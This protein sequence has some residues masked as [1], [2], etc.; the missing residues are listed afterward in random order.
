MIKLL[1]KIIHYEPSVDHKDNVKR[2]FY[3]IWGMISSVPG[4]VIYIY[5]NSIPDKTLLSDIIF[6]GIEILVL[7]LIYY[8]LVVRTAKLYIETNIGFEFYDF[9][10]LNHILKTIVFLVGQGVVVLIGRLIL[11]LFG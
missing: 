10:K 1:Y 6:F 7:G 8:M 5:Y 4:M 3:L 2:S 9:G 11:V